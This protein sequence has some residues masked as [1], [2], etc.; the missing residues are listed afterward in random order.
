MNIEE[1]KFLISKSKIKEAINLSKDSFEQDS[2][3]YNEVLLLSSRLEMLN[4]EIRKGIIDHSLSEVKRNK[5]TDD[6]MSLVSDSS[7]TS[8]ELI[9]KNI[10]KIASEF[11]LNLIQ[12]SENNNNSF[13]KN[14]YEIQRLK[15]I[16]FNLIS[17]EYSQVSLP[18]ILRR[19]NMQSKNWKQIKRDIQSVSTIIPEL[20]IA[21][22]EFSG[23]FIYKEL[24]NY[25]RLYFGLKQRQ[26]LY[27]QLLSFKKPTSSAEIKQL[28]EFADNYDWLIKEMQEIQKVLADY[29]HNIGKEGIKGERYRLYNLADTKWMVHTGIRKL[30]SQMGIIDY[31]PS[32][33]N[34]PSLYHFSTNEK[35]K[36]FTNFSS[37]EKAHE[38]K[39]KI[40]QTNVIK[41]IADKK[42][43][44]NK[45]VQRGKMA[46]F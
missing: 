20:L 39:I 40:E 36:I 25:K 24:N 11:K 44:I 6:L 1:I 29:L 30:I 5:I 38:A 31:H 13:F 27:N 28:H 33:I 7:N 9:P 18:W 19:Y 4:K 45:S 3:K 37:E 46:G 35:Y 41:K 21:I 2:D 34:H 17:M 12:A 42:K 15:G 16:I 14:D 8:F 43:G 22:E 10:T 23:D 26:E 32:L